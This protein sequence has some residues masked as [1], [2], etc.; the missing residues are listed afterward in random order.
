MPGNAPKL[1]YISFWSRRPAEYQ[2]HFGALGAGRQ[3]VEGTVED[4]AHVAESFGFGL[5]PFPEW[6]KVWAPNPDTFR[7][8]F[9]ELKAEVRLTDPEEAE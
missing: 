2:L 3:R 6:V 7:I 1:L 5:V 9:R 4:A 8:G